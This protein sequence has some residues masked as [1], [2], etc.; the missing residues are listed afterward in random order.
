MDR[1]TDGSIPSINGKEADIAEDSG[2]HEMCVKQ[3]S[4]QP[5]SNKVSV[6]NTN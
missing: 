5:I 4:Y 2:K 1:V 6:N 3:G